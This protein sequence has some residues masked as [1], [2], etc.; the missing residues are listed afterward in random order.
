M[1]TA[2]SQIQISQAIL[3][4]ML[5]HIL[6]CL[7]EEACGLLGGS[8]A[9]G[10]ARVCL[11]IENEVHSPTRFR[12]EPSAQLNAFYEFE[13]KGLDLVA[14]F[15]S[16]PAGPPMPS[17]TDLEEFAYPGVLTLIWAPVQNEARGNFLAQGKFGLR[18]FSVDGILSSRSPVHEVPVLVLPE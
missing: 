1:E 14:F 8:L 11:P 13:Q 16:H 4:Q 12:M 7:P 17:P 10:R 6:S 15:H 2:P 18:A 5:Q 3:D 9:S